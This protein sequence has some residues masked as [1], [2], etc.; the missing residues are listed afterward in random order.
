M[1]RSDPQTKDFAPSLAMCWAE[2]SSSHSWR[3][4]PW[5]QPQGQGHIGGPVHRDVGLGGGNR[6]AQFKCWELECRLCRRLCRRGQPKATLTQ[7]CSE[8]M[9]VNGRCSGH[10]SGLVLGLCSY[11][12]VLQWI[13]QGKFARPLHSL[14]LGCQLS[15]LLD[16]WPCFKSIFLYN[17]T[18]IQGGVKAIVGNLASA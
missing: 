3:N 12:E 1:L 6:T 11:N 9:Q 2:L 17:L 5:C 18:F 14:F 16:S 4:W 10:C 7:R 15:N 8:D 13:F